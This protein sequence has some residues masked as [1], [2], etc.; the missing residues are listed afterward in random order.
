MYIDDFRNAISVESLHYDVKTTG[1]VV[2]DHKDTGKDSILGVFIPRLM[3]CLDLQ[4]GIKETTL[5]TD[6]SKLLNSV[7]KDIGKKSL[8]TKNY[9]NLPV[10]SIPNMLTPKYKK[11]EN[12]QIDFVDR[13]IKFPYILPYQ[14]GNETDRRLTDTVHYWVPN[15]KNPSEK[16]TFKNTYGL[17]LDSKNQ[18]ITLYTSKN[19]GEKGTYTVTINAKDGK[20]VAS[21][22]GKRSFGIDTDKDEVYMV[23]EAKSEISMKKGDIL[24]KCKNLTEEVQNKI[25][26]TSTTMEEEY[27]Q[28]KTKSNTWKG[29]VT[30]YEFK[31]TKWKTEYTVAE[32]KHT[33][34]DQS[35]KLWKVDCP[36]SSFTTILTTDSIFV[37]APAGLP[38]LPTFANI[39]KAGIAMMGNP[40]VASMPAAVAPFTIA[41]LTTVG[42]VVDVLLAL[43]GIPPICVT[44]ISSLSPQ[45]ISR[46]TMV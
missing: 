45:I 15:F 29:E 8:K 22:S 16:I 44:T 33:K 5:S 24:I 39:N 41:A 20:L 3:F 30:S 38:P 43:F 13:D 19:N 32:D 31:G 35:A 11:G 36:L 7:N 46:T 25:K 40:A 9:I 10:A 23:N 42:T 37:G 26:I 1:T 6:T 28:M 21:D 17:M 4:D 2:K 18:I 12:V 27:K 14:F 34:Y